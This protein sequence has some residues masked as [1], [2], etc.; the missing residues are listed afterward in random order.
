[1]EERNNLAIQDLYNSCQTISFLIQ[2]QIL[3]YNLSREEMARRA[4][5]EELELEQFL[6]MRNF[7]LKTAAMY[8]L[9]GEITQEMIREK[10]VSKGMK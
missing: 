5:I 2:N 9:L 1:M 3:E 7:E 10:E 8:Q 4:E 6:T